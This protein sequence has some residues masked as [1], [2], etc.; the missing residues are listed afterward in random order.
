M[1]HIRGLYETY[2]AE[3][4]YQR[5]SD[6]YE[7]PHF[8][9]IRALIQKNMHRW[10]CSRVLDFSAGGGEVTQAL[11]ETGC[12]N[13]A[14]AD[15]YTHALYTRNTGQHCWPLSFEDV[16]KRGLPEQFS[17]IISSFALHLCEPRDLYGLC[18]QLFSAAPVLVLITPHKRP[19]LENLDGVE[20]EYTD[21]VTT[22][23]GKQV[24]LKEYRFQHYTIP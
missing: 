17:L 10:D 5:F 24:R 12:S 13:V 6:A 9:E 16:I 20:L 2:G 18:W 1:K 4:Y 19:E 15:P 23:R 7:N 8:P 3:G 11:Q 22:K 21:S 14:G